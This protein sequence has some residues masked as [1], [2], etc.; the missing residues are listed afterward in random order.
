MSVRDIGLQ[1]TPPAKT[2]DDPNCPFHGSISLRGKLIHGTTVSVR[3]KKM[4]T[5]EREYLR[6]VPKYLRYEKRR[7]KVHA[8][9]PGCIELTVGEKVTAAE[10]RRLT[11]TISFVVVEK[12][13]K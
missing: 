7:S 4:A 2:C 12:A 1:V 3:A 8:H 13:G 6:Y 5:I 10:C 11:K 9:V